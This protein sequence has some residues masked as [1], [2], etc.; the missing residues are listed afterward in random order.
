MAKTTPIVLAL[1]F[2]GKALALNNGLGLT[3]AMGW[4]SWNKF[5]CNI[6]ETVIKSNA[7]RMLDLGL[8]RAGY[9]YLNIDDCWAVARDNVTSR[10]V[11]D[12]GAFPEGVAAVADALHSRGFGFGMYADRGTKTCAGRPGSQV[13]RVN[14]SA[15]GVCPRE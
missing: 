8:D 1:L 11:P 13:A 12:P 3:P 15:G 10:L 5:G 9:R 2:L 7:R 6:D 4:N 14:G